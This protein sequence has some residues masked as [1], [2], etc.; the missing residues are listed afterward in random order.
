MTQTI[1]KYIDDITL[2]CSSIYAKEDVIKILTNLKSNPQE[3]SSLDEFL[4]EFLNQ[5][6]IKLVDIFEEK[7][8]SV[9]STFVVSY[10]SAEFRIEGTSEIALDYITVEEGNIRQ[11]LRES[12]T[13]AKQS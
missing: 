1:Q 5:F 13:E 9:D 4:N 8:D 6:L 7:L 10:S 2:E 12:I 11:L 3:D